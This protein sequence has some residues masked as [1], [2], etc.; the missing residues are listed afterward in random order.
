M[1]EDH[2]KL[3]RDFEVQ[4]CHLTFFERKSVKGWH[5]DVLTYTYGGVQLGLILVGIYVMPKEII[6]EYVRV[7]VRSVITIHTVQYVLYTYARFLRVNLWISE[8]SLN[9]ARSPAALGQTVRHRRG[10]CN[11][12][13]LHLYT[14]LFVTT[15]DKELIPTIETS[16]ECVNLGL[17]IVQAFVELWFTTK[18]SA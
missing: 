16:V 9:P 1:A 12:F 18:G 17:P 8:G 6:C 15:T 4:T 14:K 7:H 10:N 3:R 11:I 13:N 2:N 5:A